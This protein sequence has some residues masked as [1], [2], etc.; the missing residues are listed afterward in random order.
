MRAGQDGCIAL[1]VASLGGLASLDRHTVSRPLA[2]SYS[3]TGA[4]HDSCR[5]HILAYHNGANTV[6]E[7]LVTARGVL[8]LCPRQNTSLRFTSPMVKSDCYCNFIVR[9]M[10][11]CR[12]ATR[13]E[14]G[15]R[16]QVMKFDPAEEHSSAS[17]ICSDIV[18]SF[19]STHLSERSWHGTIAVRGGGLRC[20]GG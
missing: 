3:Y 14:G 18:N 2:L 16:A 15:C 11:N 8:L 20:I 10:V 12:T 17:P 6:L 4:A 13:G 9:S 19:S 7:R 1:H 5:L